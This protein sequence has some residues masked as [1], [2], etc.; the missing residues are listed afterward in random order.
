MA[1]FIDD[2]GQTQQVNLDVTMYKQAADN[3]MSFE[4]FV[5]R[6]FPASVHGNTFDQLLASEGMFLNPNKDVGLRC[7]TMD[8][9]LH[10][11]PKMEAGV[12]VK[13]AVPVSRI[14]FPAAVLSA[15]EDKLVGDLSMTP[16]AFDSMV[17]V[18]DVISNHRYERPILNFSKPEAARSQVISQL[19]LPTSMLTITASDISRSIPT[20]SLGLEISDQAMQNT[21]LDLVT[22]ALARQRA[23]E[24]NERANEFLLALLSGDADM[25]LAALSGSDYVNNADV[26]DSTISA[27]ATLTQKAW[28]KYLFHRATE[29]TITHIV[30][31][32]DTAMIIDGRTNKPVYSNT[33]TNGSITVAPAF[34]TEMQVANPMWPSNVRLFITTDTSWPAN[35]IMGFDSRYGIHRVTSSAASYEAVE[36]FVLKRSTA[37][38]FDTGEVVTRLFDD[39][40]DVLKLVNT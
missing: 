4:Q 11:R 33:T 37:M 32:I 36:N 6:Q 2:L 5:N 23:V 25:S 28:I 12:I 30:T 17:A 10:G 24:R 35:T 20:R 9:V 15:I 27:D 13:E 39:A 34:N 16:N 14:L 31:D 19:S 18:D 8:E 22:L 7:A 29:R 40:F 21:T 3:N 1:A 38:R 26:F